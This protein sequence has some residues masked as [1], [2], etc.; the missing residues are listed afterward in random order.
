MAQRGCEVGKNSSGKKRSEG[1]NKRKRRLGEPSE[2]Q[3]RLFTSHRMPTDYSPAGLGGNGGGLLNPSNSAL[4][5]VNGLTSSPNAFPFPFPFPFMPPLPPASPLYD[6]ASASLVSWIY[7]TGGLGANGGGGAEESNPA[8]KGGGDGK[9]CPP[10][11]ARGCGCRGLGELDL[12]LSCASYLALRSAFSS[13]AVIIRWLP[14][15]VGE[16]P[17]VA[18]VGRDPGLKGP[19]L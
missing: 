2:S 7:S 8:L 18:G 15:G 1:Q 3:Q 4:N 6:L 17:G 10:P 14:P 16:P 13:A 5:G 12:A 11:F 19:L 9:P